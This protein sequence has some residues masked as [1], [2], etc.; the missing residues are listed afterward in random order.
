VISASTFNGEHVFITGCS[1]FLGKVILEKLMR[2]FTCEKIYVLLRPKKNKQVLERFTKQMLG[3]RIF[4]TLRSIKGDSFET[5]ATSL[6]CPIA[7]DLLT[8]NIGISPEDR[9]VLTNSVTMIIHSA[10]SVDFDLPLNEATAI[11]IDGSLSMLALAKEC[12][13]LASFVHV[14]TCYVNSPMA[15]VV[16][17]QVYDSPFNPIDMYRRIKSSS[18]SDLARDKLEIIGAWPNTYTFTKFMAEHLLVM[19][20]GDVPLVITRPA[21]IGSSLVEPVPGWTDSISAMTAVVFA[22]SLGILPVLAGEQWKIGD[23]IPVDLCS[24]MIIASAAWRAAQWRAGRIEMLPPVVHCGTSSTPEPMT[25]FIAADGVMTYYQR[26]PVEK[27]LG[28]AKVAV[29]PKTSLH[30][31]TQRAI[32]TDIP[33]RVATMLAPHSAIF[34]K[35]AKGLKNGTRVESVFAHFTSTE[36]IFE[37]NVIDVF[38]ACNPGDEGLLF[39]HLRSDIDWHN[40]VQLLCYGLQRFCLNQEST[41][42]PLHYAPINDALQQSKVWAVG[43]QST[44]TSSVRYAI[45]GAEMDYEV[46][47]EKIL[48][49]AVLSHPEVANLLKKYENRRAARSI[50]NSMQSRF[51]YTST[52]LFGLSLE[53]MF[54]QMYDRVSVNE[55]GVRRLNQLMRSENGHPVLL[56][57]THRSYMDFLMLSYILFVYQVKVPFIVAGEDFKKIPGVNQILRRS[58]AFFMRRQLDA[59]IDPLYVAVFKAYFQQVMLDHGLVEFFIEGTRSRSGATLP[60]KHGL[61]NFAMDLVESGKA[62]GVTIVPVSMSYERVLEAESFLGEVLGETKKKETLSRIINAA[63]IVNTN[64]G[65]A[66]IYFAEPITVTRTEYLESIRSTNTKSAVNQIGLSVTNRLERNMCVM[67]TNLVAGVMLHFRSE[68]VEESR[69]VQLVEQMR[70]IARTTGWRMEVPLLGTC[71][72]SVKKCI[73]MHFSDHL[74]VSA[75]RKV[76]LKNQTE[77]VLMMAYYAQQ[78]VPVFLKHSVFVTCG[79]SEKD[80][81]IVGTILG[82]DLQWTNEDLSVPDELVGVFRTLTAAHIEAAYIALVNVAKRGGSATPL[83]TF[84][85]KVVQPVTRTMFDTNELRMFEVCSVETIKSALRN[86][87]HMEAISKTCQPVGSNTA[88]LIREINRFRFDPRPTISARL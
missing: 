80:F 7:G 35:I 40:Y 73:D 23:V 64:Y 22:I 60:P 28:P 87:V 58:G 3:S 69:L 55:E 11:N 74:V 29:I 39:L 30:Y 42:F 6:V 50:I 86:L 53:K 49:E 75:D 51:H 68:V 38:G 4:D 14:S 9:A 1:G 83:A 79:G 46:P 20:R 72:P 61:M 62:N 71:A 27:G 56:V 24:N 41:E 70:D 45:T 81:R 34:E 16:K 8:P 37:S 10:A 65:R 88:N 44:G 13:R 76:R 2:S 43:R 26:H 36:Y 77:A 33:L 21:V 19:Q 48:K 52:R 66:H 12:K 59:N 31:H 15:G 18:L 67:I 5:W 17:E 63:G 57:P 47:G 82:R 32:W 54:S 78:I 25:W 84:A 85:S